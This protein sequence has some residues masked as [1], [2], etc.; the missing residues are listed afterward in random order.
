MEKVRRKQKEKRKKTPERKRVRG[1]EIVDV[2]RIVGC[3]AGMEVEY[4]CRGHLQ[5]GQSA[6]ELKRT[7][8][9]KPSKHKLKTRVSGK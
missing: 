3:A 2:S 4:A 8:A 6:S 9:K 7:R 1:P 5:C